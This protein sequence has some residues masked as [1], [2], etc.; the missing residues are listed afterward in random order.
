MTILPQLNS[1]ESCW[2]KK[3]V[4]GLCPLVGSLLLLQLLI[5]W[6]H[7]VVSIQ[8]S[9]GFLKTSEEQLLLPPLLP[10]ETTVYT[11]YDPLDYCQPP[12]LYVLVSSIIWVNRQVGQGLRGASVSVTTF[13]ALLLNHFDEPLS[14]SR[15][16]ELDSNTYP[17][18]GDF[19][20][21]LT[22]STIYVK[23]S[24][25]GRATLPQ[26]LTRKIRSLFPRRK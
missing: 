6:S 16:W 7:L 1:M 8:L 2:L 25:A 5:S 18:A 12:L 23:H 10:K 15:F 19:T 3:D 22:T 14:P 11:F 13:L 20:C 17:S 21:I 9:F 26:I 24:A 4:D